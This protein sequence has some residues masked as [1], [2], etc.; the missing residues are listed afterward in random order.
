MRTR[1]ECRLSVAWGKRRRP[2][3]PK[4][5]QLN[6]FGRPFSRHMC[7]TDT[8]VVKTKEAKLREKTNEDLKKS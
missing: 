6:C 3:K 1:D 7:R 2:K 8:R 5:R 4:R